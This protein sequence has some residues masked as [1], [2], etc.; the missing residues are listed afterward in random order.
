MYGQ[1]YAYINP[2]KND[3]PLDLYMKLKQYNDQQQRYKDQLARQQREYQ[4]GLMT[5]AMSQLDFKHFATGTPLD[6]VIHNSLSGALK[7]VSKKIMNNPDTTLSSVYYDVANAANDI[8]TYADKARNIRANID[9]YAKEYSKNPSID[10]TKLSKAAMANAFMKYDT[11]THAFTVKD[12][13]EIDDQTDWTDY[14]LNNNPDQVVKGSGALDQLMKTADKKNYENEFSVDKGGVKKKIAYKGEYF[15]Y[16][17]IETDKN[18]HPVFDPTTGQAKVGIRSENVNGVPLA[19]KDDMA[20]FTSNPG[21]NVYLNSLVK[22]AGYDPN[23]QEGQLLKRAYLYKH[24]QD[25]NQGYINKT[26]DEVDDSQL[27]SENFRREMKSLAQT[28]AATNKANN[29][30]ASF[31]NIY[32]DIETNGANASRIPLVKLKPQS[33]EVLVNHAKSVL[34]NDPTNNNV[35][36][37]DNLWVRKNADNS[38]TLMKSAPSSFGDGMV[39][40]REI[41]PLDFGSINTLKGVNPTL[42]ERQAVRNQTTTKKKYNPKTGKFE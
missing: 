19:T 36:N 3:N 40:D 29:G 16:N 7:N 20:Y 18:G 23:S 17:T 14:T 30:S 41:A 5:Q 9:Q 32:H 8:S 13:S 6:P 37:I 2:N 28:I 42:K 35:Q 33:Q 11:N 34:G 31:D 1:E 24:L 26:K 21:A 15:P 22:K 12:P 25:N 27:Q 4:D 38:Y 10:A 39:Q